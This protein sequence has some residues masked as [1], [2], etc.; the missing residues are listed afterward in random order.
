[1]SYSDSSDEEHDELD[2][3]LKDDT[4]QPI[5][6]ETEELTE[7]NSDN[8][9]ALE[10]LRGKINPTSGSSE[11]SDINEEE[12]VTAAKKRKITNQTCWRKK[13][14]YYENTKFIGT[15]DEEPLET[16][17]SLIL[18]FKEFFDDELI[19]TITDETNL[20]SVQI[21]EKCIN[22]TSKE[23]KKFLGILIFGGLLKFPQYQIYWN[24]ST[25]VFAISDGMSVNQ[26]EQLKGFF[27]VRNNHLAPKKNDDHHDPLYKMRPIFDSVLKMS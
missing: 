8:N 7:S 21:T 25:K 15:E 2:Y 20:Y 9:C 17:K 13:K 18:H 3:C 11:V 14:R 27:H 22:T 26:F 10:T 1:M 19:Q 12:T 6:S 5:E 16:H 4:Q 24:N 23:I